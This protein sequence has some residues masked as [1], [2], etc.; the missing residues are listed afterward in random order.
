MHSRDCA[1]GPPPSPPGS[2]WQQL[3]SGLASHVDDIGRTA[4]GNLFSVPRGSL[5]VEVAADSTL[6]TTVKQLWQDRFVVLNPL[7]NPFTRFFAVTSV[8]GFVLDRVM[9]AKREAEAI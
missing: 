7:A 1:G 6:W 5:D 9:A 3:G 4:G 2:A 8:V